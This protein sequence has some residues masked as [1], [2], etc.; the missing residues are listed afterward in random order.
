VAVYIF[1]SPL[2]ALYNTTFCR[3]HPALME[4]PAGCVNFED[5]KRMALAAVLVLMPLAVFAQAR[6][7]PGERMLRQLGLTDAQVT[8]VLDIEAKTRDAM[9]QDAAQVRLLRAQI[10]KAMVASTVDMQAV[11]ALVDQLSQARGAAQKT[12]LAARVQLA[13][14]MGP[15]KLR[16][17]M[18]NLR[19]QLIRG[20]PGRRPGPRVMPWLRGG[21]FWM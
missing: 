13:Q 11:N 12:F 10:N 19:Q 16:E 2:A 15:D 9:R 21:G 17:Y 4:T 6:Q 20:A 1:F 14:I 8:Q 3:I 5:M 18:R 7:S